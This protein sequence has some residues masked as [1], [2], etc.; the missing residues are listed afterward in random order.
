MAGKND[1]AGIHIR[2]TTA[3][4][5]IRHITILNGS[6]AMNNKDNYSSANDLGIFLENVSNVK[7]ED[8]NLENNNMGIWLEGCQAVSVSGCTVKNNRYRGIYL[9]DSSNCVIDG[10]TVYSDNPEYD[11]NILLNTNFKKP[12]SVCSFNT[13]S[14]NDTETIRLQGSMTIKNTIHDNTW[15]GEP[16]TINVGS[17]VG[18]NYIY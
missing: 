3:Y 14:N 11:D 7:I 2:N 12:A 17:E 5:I 13:V 1:N 8:C 6:Q 18:E 16:S 10:N 4:V 15:E 9:M